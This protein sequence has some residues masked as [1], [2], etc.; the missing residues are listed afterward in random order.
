M[1]IEE[2]RSLPV[3]FGC[4]GWA[5]TFAFWVVGALMRCGFGKAGWVAK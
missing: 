4:P 3:P 2:G 1:G 5:L